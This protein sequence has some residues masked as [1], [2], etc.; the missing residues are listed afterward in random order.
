MGIEGGRS[1]SY[2]NLLILNHKQTTPYNQW[3]AVCV[4]EWT[5]PSFTVD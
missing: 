1:F 3:G 5:I 2:D 4:F